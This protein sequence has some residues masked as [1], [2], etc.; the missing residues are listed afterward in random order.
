MGFTVL[1]VLAS[2][3]HVNDAV[4][5]IGGDWAG[6]RTFGAGMPG[7]KGR[8]VTTEATARTLG[9][10]LASVTGQPAIAVTV[11]DER[12]ALWLAAPDG[13]QVGPTEGNDR[14]SSA[15]VVEAAG[16][17]LGAAMRSRGD[18]VQAVLADRAAPAGERYQRVVGLLGL[19]YVDPASFR[20]SP[21]VVLAYAASDAVR[22]QLPVDG[23]GAWVVPLDGSRSLVVSD[24]TG[25]VP[26]PVT[27]QGLGVR[28]ASV[29]WGDVPSLVVR[30]ADGERRVALDEDRTEGLARV[31][32]EQIGKLLGDPS[33]TSPLTDAI[34]AK[35]APSVLLALGVRDVKIGAS[36]EG[37]ASWAAARPGAVHVPAR[38]GTTLVP[39]AVSDDDVQR[40]YRR[41]VALRRTRWTTFALGVVTALGATFAWG[42]AADD[43]WLVTT[44]VLVAVLVV[45]AAAWLALGRMLK[46]PAA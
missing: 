13:R 19:E 6:P 23:H 14:E 39:R 7:G 25:P 8:L 4:R 35:R 29:A 38:P 1:Y 27:F 45:L 17:W 32:A 12:C 26:L 36:V 3:S 28:T 20:G 11:E 42:K 22:A 44:G 18:Q 2:P 15:D 33:I 5:L 30:D 24:G 16:R 31:E 37:L 10:L 34:R 43:T 40:T 21:G 41:N 9:P 46:P